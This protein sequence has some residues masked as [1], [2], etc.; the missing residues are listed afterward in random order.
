VRGGIGRAA[1]D[2]AEVEEDGADE[3]HL[4]AIVEDRYALKGD[5]VFNENGV[6]AG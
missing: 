4:R 2:L 6:G 5:E 1:E 3:G